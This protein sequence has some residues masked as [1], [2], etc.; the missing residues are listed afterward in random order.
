MILFILFGKIYV[1][2]ESKNVSIILLADVPFNEGQ[3]ATDK[4]IYIACFSVLTSI[5]MLCV[6]HCL[7]N[8]TLCQL[9][10]HK[11]IFA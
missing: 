8:T 3:Q 10:G 7:S 4:L 1:G 6:S 9:V 2:V 5:L 11:F